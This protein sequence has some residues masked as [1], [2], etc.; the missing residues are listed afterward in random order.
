MMAG[1]EE[2]PRIELKGGGKWQLSI[3][4]IDSNQFLTLI[5]IIDSGHPF[6]QRAIPVYSHTPPVGYVIFCTG[7]NQQTQNTSVQGVAE[8]FFSIVSR[9]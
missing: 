3:L 9:C 8:H 4:N 2:A 7:G 6:Q 5:A 1:R